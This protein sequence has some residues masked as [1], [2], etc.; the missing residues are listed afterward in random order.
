MNKHRHDDFVK[1]IP[2]DFSSLGASPATSS[3]YRG[4]SSD[5]GWGRRLPWLCAGLWVCLAFAWASAANAIG[6]RM[7]PSMHVI[8]FVLMS[9]L[10]L[11]CATQWLTR[12]RVGRKTLWATRGAVAAHLTIALV[13]KLAVPAVLWVTLAWVFLSSFG[14]ASRPDR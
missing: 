7:Q 5:S 13:A 8:V 9:V 12:R 2:S 1:T 6:P 11:A 10:C 14:G 4:A 3:R